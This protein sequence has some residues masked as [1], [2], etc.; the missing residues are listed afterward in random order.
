VTVATRVI[1]SMVDDLTSKKSKK[2]R[3][4]DSL[5]VV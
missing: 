4:P 2:V 1:E 5:E 3:E